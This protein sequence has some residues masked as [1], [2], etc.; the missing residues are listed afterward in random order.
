MGSNFFAT[1]RTSKKKEEVAE[2]FRG[3]NVNSDAKCVRINCTWAELELE[4]STSIIM[5]GIISDIKVDGDNVLSILRMAKVHHSAEVYDANDNLY[6][7]WKHDPNNG[8]I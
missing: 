1:L 8:D 6:K 3:W 5:H 2:L 4:E 7:E